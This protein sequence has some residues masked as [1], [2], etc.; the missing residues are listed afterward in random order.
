MA[1]FHKLH[2]GSVAA[3]SQE[4]LDFFYRQPEASLKL[5]IHN[6][7][8]EHCQLLTPSHLPATSKNRSHW[9]IQQSPFADDYGRELLARPA[10][11]ENNL[12][13]AIGITATA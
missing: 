2:F 4:R 6:V 3:G 1:A 5:F 10:A 11:C 9:T 8:T 12:F 13:A 7:L